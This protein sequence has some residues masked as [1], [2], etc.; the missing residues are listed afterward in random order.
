MASS[1]TRYFCLQRSH[2]TLWVCTVTWEQPDS[3]KS[4]PEDAGS[5]SLPGSWAEGREARSVCSP[6]CPCA[7][8]VSGRPWE[9]QVVSSSFGAQL[10][11]IPLAFLWILTSCPLPQPSISLWPGTPLSSPWDHCKLCSFVPSQAAWCEPLIVSGAVAS[12][13][14]CSTI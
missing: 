9:L 10:L 2:L 7:G 3:F 8:T 4:A 13:I 1:G 14:L 11:S 6:L 12:C 5:S